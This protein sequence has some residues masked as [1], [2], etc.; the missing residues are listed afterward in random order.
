MWYYVKQSKTI[1]NLKVLTDNLYAWDL[2]Y[3]ETLIYKNTE[4]IE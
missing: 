3:F 2:F 1:M 4:K